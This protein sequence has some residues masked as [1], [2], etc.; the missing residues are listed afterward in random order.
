MDED[1]QK[2]IATLVRKR[3]QPTLSDAVYLMKYEKVVDVLTLLSLYNRL[4]SQW[5]TK[6][7]EEDVE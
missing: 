6:K 4:R 3:S 1:R 5:H 2:Y 7:N